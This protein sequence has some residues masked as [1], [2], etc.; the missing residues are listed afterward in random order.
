MV[1]ADSMNRRISSD[2]QGSSTLEAGASIAFSSHA[3]RMTVDH[4]PFG[5]F[6]LATNRPKTPYQDMP[7]TIHVKLINRQKDNLPKLSRWP[8]WILPNGYRGSAL[9]WD[10]NLIARPQQ[11]VTVV[12]YEKAAKSRANQQKVRLKTC[13]NRNL[14]QKHWSQ[15]MKER[16]ATRNR[17][18]FWWVCSKTDCRA[19]LDGSPLDWEW[20]GKKR[21]KSVFLTN[22][23]D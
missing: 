9:Q 3:Y 16:K 15:G 13:Q 2:G 19:L 5:Q 7:L 20:R 12:Q 4:A 22:R 8:R 23:T 18:F 1:T 14:R 10:A 21:E 6:S 17:P 11:S